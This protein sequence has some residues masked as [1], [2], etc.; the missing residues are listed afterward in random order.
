MSTT[1][2]ELKLELENP[3]VFTPLQPLGVNNNTT[4]EKSKQNGGVA[5]EDSSSSPTEEL[6]IS[7]RQAAFEQ[8]LEEAATEV[9]NN[10]GGEKQQKNNDNDSKTTISFANVLSTFLDSAEA[11]QQDLLKGFEAAD[12]QVAALI[13]WLGEPATPDASP[14]FQMV[15]R[16][17]GEFDM[18]MK[19]VHRL[20]A[21]AA[22]N[23][24]K[25]SGSEGGGGL[26]LSRK[27]SSVTLMNSANSM[28]SIGNSGVR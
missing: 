6:N 23:K 10:G 14:I 5:T 9:D 28:G 18:C 2:R 12:T 21:V 3:T 16:F 8:S 1:R 20:A 17:V 26:S 27:S 15:L 25:G 13:A 11:Q 19:K 7:Q 4:S 24:G 22:A